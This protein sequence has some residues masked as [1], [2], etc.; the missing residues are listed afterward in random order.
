MSRRI[1]A[2]VPVRNGASD[3]PAFLASLTELADSVLALDDG[4]TDHT[5]DLLRASPRV[6]VVLRNPM[7]PTAAG[8]DDA[9]NRTRLLEAAHDFDPGFVVWFDVDEIVDEQD[10]L[11]LRAFLQ[12]DRGQH[13]AYGVRVFRMI[14]DLARYDK[15]GLWVYRIFPFRPGLTLPEDRLH[16]EP[17]PTQIV[18]AHWR[19]TTVRLKHLASLTETRRRERY[20]KYLEADPERRWQDSYENLLHPPGMLRPWVRRPAGLPILWDECD[21]EMLAQFQ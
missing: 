20:Q 14:D 2:L 18:A 6:D 1:V 17:I 11:A 21:T 4:S 15:A 8:W 5:Y 10:A 19:K 9:A 12:N 7:R 3:L 16:F 13:V